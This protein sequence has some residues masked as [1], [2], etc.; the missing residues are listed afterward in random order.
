MNS[1][2]PAQGLQTRF[3]Q[4]H[5]AGSTDPK[6]PSPPGTGVPAPGHSA[7]SSRCSRVVQSS[8][9]CALRG[10]GM[11]V[12]G[13]P[14]VELPWGMQRGAGAAILPQRPL[15]DPTC[16]R[17]VAQSTLGRSLH[18]GWHGT[19]AKH[20]IPKMSSSKTT[21]HG[22]RAATWQLFPRVLPRVSPRSSSRRMCW[23]QGPSSCTA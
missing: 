8:S 4:N 14:E 23:G 1:S 19:V 21:G 11:E 5:A 10:A 7:R 17:E 12:Q 22:H 16:G 9:A 15:G 18:G 3:S 13:I 2:P 20:T 6:T